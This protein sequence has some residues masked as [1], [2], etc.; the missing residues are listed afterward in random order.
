MENPS[1]IIDVGICLLL[2][3]S[4]PKLRRYEGS[5]TPARVTSW[6]PQN[7]VKAFHVIVLRS[8]ELVSPPVGS[9]WQLSLAGLI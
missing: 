1:C 2:G 5:R 3:S 7:M 4:V 9:H 6:H 8:F